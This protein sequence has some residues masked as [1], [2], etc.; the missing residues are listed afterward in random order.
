[1]KK[2]NVRVRGAPVDRQSSA[3]RTPS[4]TAGAPA[5]QM[6]AEAMNST[7]GFR[8]SKKVAELTQVVHMLFVRNHEK[9]IENEALRA[10]Y[11]DEIAEVIA[12]AKTRLAALEEHRQTQARRH[13]EESAQG[14]RRLADARAQHDIEWRDRLTSLEGELQE[15]KAECG[16]VRDL[17]INAQK[18]IERLKHGHEREQS[19]KQRDLDA[20]QNEISRMK[21]HISKL[22]H[23]ARREEN[24]AQRM[25]DVVQTNKQLGSKIAHLHKQVDSLTRDN[26]KL[27]ASNKQLESASSIQRDADKST[28]EKTGTRREFTGVPIAVFLVGETVALC[29]LYDLSSRFA[30]IFNTTDI[31]PD[32]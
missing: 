6:A 20:R 10:A 8:M 17:L 16:N 26:Q 21:A 4:A 2:I 19:M 13:D 1:M 15:V 30:N 29:F 14:E 28:T 3:G 31:A 18:D 9:E 7:F 5:A 32:R 12:D 11:E 23:T 25:R 24:E 22:E 27:A